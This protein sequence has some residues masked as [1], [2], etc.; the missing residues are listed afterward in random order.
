MPRLALEWSRDDSPNETVSSCACLL[1]FLIVFT[2]KG[3][4]GTGAAGTEGA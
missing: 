3:A 4:V 1:F 2:G